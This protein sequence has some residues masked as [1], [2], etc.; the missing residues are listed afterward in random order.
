MAYE[1]LQQTII[2][3]N[4]NTTWLMRSSH[5]RTTLAYLLELN[6]LASVEKATCGKYG[7]KMK[8]QRFVHSDVA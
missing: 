2:A 4:N 8:H 1:E 7:K 5:D 6:G 3:N